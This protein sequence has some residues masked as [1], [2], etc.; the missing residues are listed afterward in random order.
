MS[1]KADKEEV[2]MAVSNI[3]GDPRVID[4]LIAAY[5][6]LVDMGINTGE[7]WAL[8][9][10]NCAH[11]SAMF[12]RMEENLNYSEQRLLQVWPTRFTRASARQCANNP[13]ALANFVYNGRL[14]NRAGTDDG[15]N[16]RGSG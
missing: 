14:G 11:E 3:A 6:K 4:G 15:W 2:I 7:R 1:I 5:D 9:L 16:F 8:F 12:T 13:K 10:G